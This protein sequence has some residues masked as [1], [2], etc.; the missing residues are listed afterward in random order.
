MDGL[1]EEGDYYIFTS[2]SFGTDN[3]V[4]VTILPGEHV[5]RATT[6]TRSVVSWWSPKN[7]PATQHAH[8]FTS[9][10]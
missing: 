6:G 3:P 7:S 4:S 10:Q 9:G 2:E 1:P 8:A 5:L